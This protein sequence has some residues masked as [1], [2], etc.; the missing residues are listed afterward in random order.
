MRYGFGMNTVWRVSKYFTRHRGLF[1]LTMLL[2]VLATVALVAIPR[3]ILHILEGLGDHPS[4]GKLWLGVSVIA[5][6]YALRELFNS[7]RIRVN[8]ILEQKVLMDLRRDV[9]S[10]LLE[11]PMGLSLIHI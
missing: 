7:L 1:L 10:R 4:T 8:N 2:A 5:V 3:R 9:H 11:L 6:L